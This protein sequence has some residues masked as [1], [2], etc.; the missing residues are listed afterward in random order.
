MKFYKLTLC[1]LALMGA[2]A[3]NDGDDASSANFDQG[4]LVLDLNTN[5][6]VELVTRASISTVT[7]YTAPTKDL[8]TFTVTN[9]DNEIVW[10]G[11]IADLTDGKLSLDA[12]S[13]KVTAEYSEG[14]NMGSP[15]FKG[16][17]SN[18]TINGGADTAVVVPV[19]LT[20]A[21]VK[22][23][24]DE[25]FK[26]YYTWSDFT[27]SSGGGSATLTYAAKETK[28]VFINN[29]DLTIEGTLTAQAQDAN[30]TAKSIPFKKTFTGIKAG[31]CYTLTFTASNIGNAGKITI[32]FGNEVEEEIDIPIEVNPEE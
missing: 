22:L 13:Y 1:A 18:V 6:D 20:N 26:G 28:G 10:S 27:L 29:S 12:G 17:I 25:M 3:C 15:V 5:Q 7:G 32:E 19:S 2:V 4:T 30:F 24:F 23:E 21:I 31:K 9:D 11:K 16:S 8:F 14:G